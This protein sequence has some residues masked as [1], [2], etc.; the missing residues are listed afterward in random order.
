[1][2][3]EIIKTQG[4]TKQVAIAGRPTVSETISEALVNTG[5]ASVVSTV[6]SN[7]GAEISDKSLNKAVDTLGEDK[8][9]QSALL[10]RNKLPVSVAEKLVTK[11]SEKMQDQ[12]LQR[13]KLSA[14]IATDLILQS[15]ERATVSLSAEYDEADVQILVRHL[16]QNNRLTP[17]II[18]RALCMGDLRFFEASLAE[19]A[20][21]PLLNACALIHDPGKRGLERLWESAHLPK[22]Q[23]IAAFAA[24]GAA[25]ELEYDGEAN[26][27][28][29][30]SRRLIEV[31]LTQYDDLG[32]EFEEADLEYLLT[33]MG[34][35]PSNLQENA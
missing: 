21:I 20:Q 28:E 5:K 16:K 6:V 18:L 32:V 2:L 14:D 17:S 12:L 15:R 27:R 9:V 30:F 10:W 19:L 3:A 29:R 23:L 8:K 1:D 25:A 13:H 22:P 11:V 34:S 26:D 31:V 7:E 35:L 33:K 4:E 24:I